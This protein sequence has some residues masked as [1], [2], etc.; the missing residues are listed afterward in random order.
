MSSPCRIPYDNLKALFI[1]SI[2][3]DRGTYRYYR[4]SIESILK[5]PIKDEAKVHAI[6]F[7]GIVYN[8]ALNVES[9]TETN[10]IVTEG[11]P[12]KISDLVKDKLNE[13]STDFTE[14]LNDLKELLK[15]PVA[16]DEADLSSGVST[17]TKG[18]KLTTVGE[19]SK[20]NNELK[21]AVL[22]DL[23]A[24]GPKRERLED[25][26]EQERDD[27]LWQERGFLSTGT[28]PKKEE[29]PLTTAQKLNNIFTKLT[30]GS[31]ATLN[32]LF[33]EFEDVINKDPLYDKSAKINAYN[34]FLD[35]I[36]KLKNTAATSLRA[37]IDQKKNELAQSEEAQSKLIN[38]R[39]IPVL[40]EMHYVR[41]KNGDIKLLVFKNGVYFSYNPK[42]TGQNENVLEQYTVEPTDYI[43]P[44]Y[45]KDNLEV[46]NPSGS[47]FRLNANLAKNGVGFE[48]VRL[49]EEGIEPGVTAD[50]RTGN[51]KISDGLSLN[52]G[53]TTQIKIVA[54][55]RELELLY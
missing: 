10:G 25:L 33:D 48:D 51:Q 30:K 50:N 28:S 31:N 19:I 27:I 52:L 12:I 1:K 38:L 49:Y 55:R 8:N 5:M 42:Y 23:S 53:L 44:V 9:A 29:K 11:L 39:S 13:T 54:D 34:K 21:E 22:T 32:N 17:E 36:S 18:E 16:A 7:M 45:G 35:G 3:Y 6:W 43:T 14:L 4:K 41:K 26:R 46:T 15:E 2:N 20:V 40:G 24:A 37:L 47:E